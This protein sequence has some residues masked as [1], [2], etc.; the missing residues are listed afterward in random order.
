MPPPFSSELNVSI[1]LSKIVPEDRNTRTGIHVISSL[2]V[3]S[4]RI[5]LQLLSG[6]LL[7]QRSRSLGSTM[8]P[9]ATIFPLTVTVPQAAPP[10]IA[11]PDFLPHC[12]MYRPRYDIQRPWLD[13]AFNKACL[14]AIAGAHLFS[15]LTH[16]PA[17][18]LRLLLN[19]RELKL[20][21]SWK[22][23]PCWAFWEMTVTCS[24]QLPHSLDT[25]TSSLLSRLTKKG[26][27]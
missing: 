1:G 25:Q 24:D 22:E 13:D 6:H 7:S 11:Q 5:I 17:S 3:P 4:L 19:H 12:F 27:R 9:L 16:L 21:S 8:P 23:K 18:S 15:S 10:P 20:P 2:G 14:I 26:N